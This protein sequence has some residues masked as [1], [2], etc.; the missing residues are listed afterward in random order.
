MMYALA[1]ITGAIGLIV[2]FLLAERR[3]RSA[4][5]AADQRSAGL[6]QQLNQQ[7]LELSDVRQNCSEA[8]KNS[9]AMGA[10][11][12]SARQNILEQRKLLDDANEQL[13][14]SFAV[15]SAEAL[16]KNNEAFLHLAKERFATLSTEAAGT[17]DQR[18][19]E[20]DGMLKPMQEVLNQ[21]QTPAWRHRKIPR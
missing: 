18:K 19:A 5:A 1:I 8:E 14:Q 7:T 16:A 11:L 4:L 15:V 21:Y 6:S 3:L 20:I 12:Q 17:L 13:R 10:Q 9:A 2:G